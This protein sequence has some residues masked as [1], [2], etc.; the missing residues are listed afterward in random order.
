MFFSVLFLVLVHIG[1][2]PSIKQLEN[3]T[4][5]PEIDVVQVKE[6]S[7]EALKLAQEAKIDVQMV[8]T[9]LTDIDQRLVVLSEEVSSVSLAKIEE[10]ENRLSLLIEAF[11]DLHEQM[12]AIEVLPQI[13]VSKKK[14]S[15]SFSPSDAASMMTSTEYEHYQTALRLYDA[16]SYDKAIEQFKDL[17]EKYPDGEYRD[18]AQYWV[19]ECHYAKGDYANAIASFNK[20][21]E[22]KQTS[23]ADDAQLKLG[24]SY[25]RMGKND[26]AA[27]EF[28]RL[29]NRYPASEYVPRAEKYLSE[30]K[31]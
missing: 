21:L 4:L 17:L 23:K 11:K 3:E 15:A 2:G 13:R 30:I 27:D 22:Y 1:C 6:Y 14:G 25:L 10:L 29:I 26:V 7:E 9:K 18:K 12:A 16:R 19:A 31:M 28:K 24:L 20:V 8:N 5:L